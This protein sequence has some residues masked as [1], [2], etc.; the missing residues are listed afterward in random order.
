MDA[1]L[2]CFCGGKCAR[3]GELLVRFSGDLVGNLPWRRWLRA[4]LRGTN[5][6]VSAELGGGS[7]WFRV[8]R[9]ECRARSHGSSFE[10]VLQ[11]ENRARLTG[12]RVRIL[13]MMTQSENFLAFFSK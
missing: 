5:G 1:T 11:G 6:A 13:A 10:R 2:W 12:R 4:S 7:G 8:I 9:P 3:D